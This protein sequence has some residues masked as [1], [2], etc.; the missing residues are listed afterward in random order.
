MRGSKLH[1]AGLVGD[2]RRAPTRILALRTVAKTGFSSSN[3]S[4]VKNAD[5]S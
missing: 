1:R 3:G 4:S 5:W 2:K